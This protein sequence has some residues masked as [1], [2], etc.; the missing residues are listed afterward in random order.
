MS[1]LM[2]ITRLG[3]LAASKH[4]ALPMLWRYDMGGGSNHIGKI[5]TI[6]VTVQNAEG[7]QCTQITSGIKKAS[8]LYI[9]TAARRWIYRRNIMTKRESI[10]LNKWKLQWRDLAV[11]MLRFGR[12][13]LFIASVALDMEKIQEV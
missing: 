12:M 8:T 9:H 3:I 5:V 1:R 13:I 6:A 4:S 2:R 7:R 11:L 10:S